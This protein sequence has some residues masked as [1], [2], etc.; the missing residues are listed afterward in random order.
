[1]KH[2]D[3]IVPS[4]EDFEGVAKAVHG[5]AP[6]TRPSMNSIGGIS[7]GE[8]LLYR[9]KGRALKLCVSLG[10]ALSSLA[11]VPASVSSEDRGRRIAAV[12]LL[13]VCWLLTDYYR[14]RSSWVPDVLADRRWVLAAAALT[15]VPYAIDGHA[16]SDAFMG[17]APLAGIAATT[18]RRREVIAFAGISV[19]AY[20]VGVTLG[21]GSFEVLTAAE[22]PFDG[23]Q[24]IAAI[25]ACC[26]LFA[27]AVLGFRRFIEEI[28]NTVVADSTNVSPVAGGDLATQDVQGRRSSKQQPRLTDRER[29][30]IGLLAKDKSRREIAETLVID[31]K[32]VKSHI[33]S[34]KSKLGV[35]RQEEAVAAY[36]ENHPEGG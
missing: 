7:A 12:A 14:K 13:L 15:A 26:G 1:M 27:F 5:A 34:A 16:Q 4:N 30:V 33:D 2:L 32:T 18:C 24:Q 36:M 21:G 10:I 20:T 8:L 17:L 3:R 23:V 29:E 31:P 35:S 25:V 11:L 6:Y 28:P 19:V 22:H 9:F